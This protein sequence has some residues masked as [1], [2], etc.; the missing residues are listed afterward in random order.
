[1]S[2]LVTIFVLGSMLLFAGIDPKALAGGG[3][4][5]AAAGAILPQ[6]AYLVFTKEGWGCLSGQ[7]LVADVTQ[8]LTT[9]KGEPVRLQEVKNSEDVDNRF[10]LY[11]YYPALGVSGLPGYYVLRLRVAGRE[12]QAPGTL[13][14]AQA[15]LVRGDQGWA[16]A[17]KGKTAGL[18]KADL[19][20]AG[21]TRLES[22]LF[23]CPDADRFEAH[24]VKFLPAYPIRTVMASTATKLDP[25]WDNVAIP[26]EDL[27]VKAGEAMA[28][29][30]E[31]L[32]GLEQN[33][34]ASKDYVFL[35]D[36]SK[37]T[38]K[39]LNLI[40]ASLEKEK[41]LK[42]HVKIVLRDQKG[43]IDINR[44][45]TPFVPQL[46]QMMAVKDTRGKIIGGKV[47]LAVEKPGPR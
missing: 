38:S 18:L 40:A 45:P 15:A 47:W 3:A 20:Y 23:T 31:L 29:C 25:Q 21:A 36:Q 26:L 22:A 17:L 30:I 32:S 33:F 44:D 10:E 19:L 43:K 37:I 42:F 13:R 16:F 27:Q 24:P 2:R 41:G 28:A 8:N 5:A 14:L 1:M 9:P 34:S 4:G 7:E 12:P 39:S 11:L 46:R 35:W 6:K